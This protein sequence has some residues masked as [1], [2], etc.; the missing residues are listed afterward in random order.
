MPS[1]IVPSS[2]PSEMSNSPRS[3]RVMKRNGCRPKSAVRPARTSI[4]PSDASTAAPS[5]HGRIEAGNWSGMQ[6][7]RMEVLVGSHEVGLQL[8]AG[9]VG[10][11]FP[12]RGTDDEQDG[13][14][15][16]A[17]HQSPM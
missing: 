15:C 2:S 7:S 3:V 1:V 4:A 13:L 14:D 5:I 16:R 9:R 10:E 17:F 8:L 6:S 11:H 12:D